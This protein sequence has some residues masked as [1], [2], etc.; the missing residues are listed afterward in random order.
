MTTKAIVKELKAAYGEDYARRLAALK[1]LR[2]AIIAR[3]GDPAEKRRRLKELT[4]LPTS[5]L[6]ELAASQNQSEQSEEA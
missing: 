2:A 1:T 5:K 3:A 4:A 6:A